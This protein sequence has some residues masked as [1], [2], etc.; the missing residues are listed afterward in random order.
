MFQYGV[1]KHVRGALGVCEIGVL[2]DNLSPIDSKSLP[3][4]LNNINQTIYM[5]AYIL[6]CVYECMYVYDMSV[7]NLY[8]DS[9]YDWYRVRTVDDQNTSSLSQLTHWDRDQMDAI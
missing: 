7:F 5:S 3:V 2:E 4:A 1:L 8:T 6:T 9:K